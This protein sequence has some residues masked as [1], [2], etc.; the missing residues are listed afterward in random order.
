MAHPN[1]YDDYDAGLLPLEVARYIEQHSDPERR[2]E[3]AGL[4]APDARVVD[5]G[6]EYSGAD[7]IR[8][9]LNRAAS[10]YS[11][12]VTPLGQRSTAAGRWV[13]LVRLEGTFPGGVVDLRYR[14]VCES[15]SISD[16]VIA[17]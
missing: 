6:I 2:D 8:G 7:E 17:P 11:Y 10:E 4:F 15:G 13:V 5:E 9:W 3:I 1:E 16:L 12:T 14:V